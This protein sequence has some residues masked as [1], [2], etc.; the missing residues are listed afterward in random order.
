[1][2]NRPTKLPQPEPE[3]IH[4]PTARNNNNIGEISPTSNMFKRIKAHN[5]FNTTYTRNTK[6]P[7]YT[8]PTINE[9]TSLSRAKKLLIMH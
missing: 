2:G 6:P 5:P 9:T 3:P 8:R 4:D 1:M 7:I